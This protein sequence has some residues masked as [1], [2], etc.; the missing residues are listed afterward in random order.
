MIEIVAGLLILA[1]GAFGVIAG[2]GVLRMPDIMIR[3]H[4]STKIGTL[5]SALILLAAML[6][7]A[8]VGVTVRAAAVFIFLLLTAPIAAHMIG[9]ASIRAGLPLYRITGRT[10]PVTEAE[11]RT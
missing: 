5:S 10:P 6:L 1:G 11:D 4:A 3:M 2:I 7:F 9:R 8:D